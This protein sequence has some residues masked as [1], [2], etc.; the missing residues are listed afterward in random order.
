MPYSRKEHIVNHQ[1]WRNIVLNSIY[2]I[3]VLCV[4]L[5]EGDHFFK[6]PYGINIDLE[7]W[8]HENGQHLSLFFNIFVFLQVFNFFNCRKLKRDEI[9][10]F[11]Q[12]FDNYIF[13]CIVVIIFV[14]EIVM[15]QIGGRV[16]MMVPLT[17]GQHIAC[18]VIGF[19]MVVYASIIKVIVPESFLDNFELLKEHEKVEHYHADNQF[20]AFL[21]QPAT[22]RRHSRMGRKSRTSN[23]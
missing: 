9:N 2:Q 4:V 5:F 6:V 7:D 21:Q 11:T 19:T 20:Q 18:I 13:I 22:E 12:F 10:P 23:H 3:I 16:M 15:V 1:M 8:N 14:I 17:A